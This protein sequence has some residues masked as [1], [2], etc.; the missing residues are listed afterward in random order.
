[1]RKIYCDCCTKEINEA[2][3]N[4][5]EARYQEVPH[6]VMD[7]CTE[8][9][10]LG[11]GQLKALLHHRHV[12]L[13]S[14][15]LTSLSASRVVAAAIKW[16]DGTIVVGARH[17][18]PLMNQ[19]IRLLRQSAGLDLKRSESVQGFIDQHRNFLTRKEAWGIAERNGQIIRDYCGCPGVLYSES[20]Y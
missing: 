7:L 2:P 14:Y 12:M 10:D 11:I 17:H 6:L 13:T 5:V 16:S 18:D 9:Y 15:A 1:M 19:T 4:S 20:L 8:C 3:R